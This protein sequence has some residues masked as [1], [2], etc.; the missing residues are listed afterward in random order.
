VHA[1]VSVGQLA[2][3]V[4]RGTGE[5]PQPGVELAGLPVL[6]RPEV[7]LFLLPGLL[8]EEAD[9]VGPLAPLLLDLLAGL[10]VGLEEGAGL[11]MEVL[12]ADRVGHGARVR[13]GPGTGPSDAS[14]ARVVH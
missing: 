10:G 12:L 1:L 3:A 7:L 13:A 2:A 14:T 11:V 4:L 9:A 6:G 8:R 5:P